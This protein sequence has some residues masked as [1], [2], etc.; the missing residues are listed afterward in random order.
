MQL[1]YAPG[2]CALGIHILLEEIGA[3]YD[4]IRVDLR[5]RQQLT[6]EFRAL[7]PKAKVPVL[8]RDDGT[9]LTEYPA[10]SFWL[11]RSFPAAGLL[12]EDVE[13]QARAL[14]LIDYVVSTV[15][16]RGF[17]LMKLP[18]KYV[19]NPEGQAEMHAAAAKVLEDG[20]SVLS[21]RLGADDWFLGGYS[22]AD[23]AAFYVV[24]WAIAEGV[25]VPGNLLA[26]HQRM[27]A[28][29]AVAAALT[30]ETTA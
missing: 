4:A 12:G 2:S 21:D 7:N 16:M 18:Q 27:T 24:N 11:A 23:P 26:F 6:P 30:A 15:H 3:P 8:V 5:G 9:V 22:I 25:A 14:E 17:T 13:A 19:A 10:I 1:H 20:L 29:P 28:R